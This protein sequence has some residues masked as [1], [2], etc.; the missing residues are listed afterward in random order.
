MLKK[1]IIVINI[2]NRNRKYYQ[3]KGYVCDQSKIEIDVKDLPQNSH[4]KVIAICKFCQKEKELKYF[5]YLENFNR[6]NFYSCKSCSNE[7]R[8]LTCLENYG[9]ENPQQD[10]KIR[11]KT[12]ETNIQKYGFKTSLLNNDIKDKIKQTNLEKYGVEDILSSTEIRKKIKNTNL[13]KYGK[14]WYTQTESYYKKTYNRWLNEIEIKLYNYNIKDFKIKEDRT[15]DIKCDC[16]KDHY[17]NINSK[18]L[19]Q[20]YSIQNS[21]LCTICNSIDNST[22]SGKEQEIFEFINNNYGG[23]ILQS[24]TTILNGKELDIYLPDLKIAIEFNG[25]YWHSELYKDKNYHLEKTEKCEEKDIHLIHIYEDEWLYKQD[26]V[27]SRLLNLL[28]KSPNKIY[29]RK[30]EL[31]EIKDNKLIRQFLNDNHLQGFVDSGVKIGL[32]QNNDLVSI[33]TFGKKRKTHNSVSKEREYEL[34]RFCNKINTN[35]I[36]GAGKLFKYFTRN[37]NP[38]EIISYADRSW[39]KGNL[40]E[41]LNF[42]FDSKTQPNYYYFDGKNIKRLYRFNYRKDILV[43]EGFDPD[44]SEHQIM[45]ER[46]FSRIYNSGNLKYRLNY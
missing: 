19:Y 40:Y 13:E 33:M 6:H 30:T 17:F 2:T 24:N 21:I 22:I 31:K 7:S 43:K 35:V 4:V 28:N 18:N 27:K 34:L 10:E 36:G 37:Y 15:V 11:K 5:K 45:S 25:L 12:I 44:K 16:G 32:Y 14:E 1:N 46:G 26:I 29:A 3:E 20:R 8:K 23:K 42:K 41:K 9:V 39:S 38:K